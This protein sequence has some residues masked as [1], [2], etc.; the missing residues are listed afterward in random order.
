MG[1]RGGTRTGYGMA[2][3]IDKRKHYLKAISTIEQ[4]RQFINHE[5]LRLSFLSSGIAVSGEYTI[6]DSTCRPIDA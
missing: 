4:A 2:R 3:K 5:E 1:K 6:S